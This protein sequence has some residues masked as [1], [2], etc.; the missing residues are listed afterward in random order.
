MITCPQCGTQQPDGTAFCDNCGAALNETPGQQPQAG[1][2][3]GQPGAPTVVAS[4]NCPSCGASVPP[5]E[6][7]CPNCGAQLG[8]G[9][10]Q[11]AYQQAQP[12]PTP[13]GQL[14]CSSCGARLEPDSAFCDMCGA[15]VQGAA[16]SPQPQEQPGPPQPQPQQPPEAWSSP[17]QIPPQYQ[18]S[19]AGWQQQ[20]PQPGPVGGGMQARLIVQRT[21]TTLP[22]PPG[23]NQ[24]IIGRE[25]PVSG[26]FPEID[27]TDHGG[28]EGGVSRKHARIYTQ[29][30]QFYIED[31]QS[32][33]YTF[34]NQQRVMPGQ[35]QPL[36]NGDEIRL[37]KVKLTFQQM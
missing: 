13:G 18:E 21:N 3:M 29:G 35:P 6:P 26:I 12:G 32:V 31:L 8:A 2:Q 20:P 19:Y 9:Q 34:V 7:Y 30:G 10:P 23:K 1:A 14:T 17:Q 28:D 25:D 37:G 24:I 4:N 15:P 27:L 5:G 11:Q 16:P 33:N 36:N 22:F